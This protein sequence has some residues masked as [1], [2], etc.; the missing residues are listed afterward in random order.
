MKV[1]ETHGGKTY[2]EI[3]HGLDFA[4]SIFH[5]SFISLYCCSR[6]DD[7]N[8]PL[9]NRLHDFTDSET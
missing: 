8:Q 3:Q 1:T 5:N 2:L 6:T 4:Q 9:P 7:S